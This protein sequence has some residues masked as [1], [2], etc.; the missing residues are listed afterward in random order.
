MLG[1]ASMRI[2]AKSGYNTTH[3]GPHLVT[4]V[5]KTSA[6]TY[7]MIGSRTPKDDYNAISSI[8]GN[9]SVAVC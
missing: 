8:Y 7:Q 6:S 3:Q 1:T 4:S 2:Q 5:S 9:T